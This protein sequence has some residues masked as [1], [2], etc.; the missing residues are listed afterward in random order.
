MMHKV[1]PWRRI[2]SLSLLA[3]LA[4]CTSTQAPELVS[5]SITDTV[6]ISI[7]GTNDIHGA[8]TGAPHVGGM[9]LLSG[10]VNNL[11]ALRAADGGTVLLID[12]GDMW[13]G[14]LESNLTEGASVVAAFNALGYTA[15]AFGNHEFDFGPVGPQSTPEAADDDPQGAMKL[16]AVEA[17]FPMLAAN[18]IDLETGAPVDWE[19]VQ[20]SVMVDLGDVK[21]GIIGVMTEHAIQTTILANSRGLRVDP[22]VPT[23]TEHANRLRAAGAA[24]IIVTAHAGSQCEDFSNPVD[25]SSCDHQGEIFRVANALLPGTVDV[26]IAGHDHSGVAHIVNGIAVASAFARNRAIDRID[27]KVDPLTG[28]IVSREI[29]APQLLCRYLSV[30]QLNCAEQTRP[31][32]P[33][34]AAMYAGQP[35]VPDIAIAETIAP[36]IERAQEMKI[37]E[38]GIYLETEFLRGSIPES[39]VGNLL[40]DTLLESAAD[41]DFAMHN[42]SGG[43]RADLPSGELLYGSLYEMFPFDNRMTT[44]ELSGAELRRVLANQMSSQHWRAG[45]SGGKV[46]ARCVE[47]ELQITVVRPWGAE[48]RDDEV[49]KIVTADF[50]A[51]GGNGIFSEVIPPGG[52]ALDGDAPLIRDVMQKWLSER[53]G[54]ISAD[55]FHDENS[56]RF[57]YESPPPID[58]TKRRR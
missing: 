27:L 34:A 50:L 39:S 3:S 43:I 46:I 22:I 1:K 38:I 13:Q 19:N 20:P 30:Q 15:A 26:I 4:A 7:V 35:V 5:A 32:L 12:A 11:R 48:V 17:Q 54:A 55:M 47:K 2:F 10:Y 53:G 25:L 51:T 18:L 41:A 29:H 16:R 40:M 42:S 23:V 52:F 45:F 21:V 36:A 8:L 33:L 44:I 37:E 9:E 56:R 58:C 6:T 28:M 57:I 14:T 31:D 49:L 24:I